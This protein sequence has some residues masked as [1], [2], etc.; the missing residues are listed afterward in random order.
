MYQYKEVKNPKYPG[1]L[2]TGFQWVKDEDGN[3]ITNEQG[4]FAYTE[5]PA[6]EAKPKKVRAAKAPKAAKKAKKVKE[7]VAETSADL[8]SVLLL[9]KTYAGLSYDA[10]EKI[11]DITNG[12]M[13]KVKEAEKNALEK[14]ISKLQEKLERLA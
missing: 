14:E 2:P 6:S 9:K 3:I 1:R 13:D 10:L 11:R 4:H 7:E 12:L 8:A 5:A